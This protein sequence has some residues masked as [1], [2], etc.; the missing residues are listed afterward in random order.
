MSP[1]CQQVCLDLSCLPS[2]SPITSAGNVVL[3]L[4]RLSSSVSRRVDTLSKVSCSFSNSVGPCFCVTT[5][6]SFLDSG[7]YSVLN[8]K[9]S[10]YSISLASSIACLSVV[11]FPCKSS[12]R[13]MDGSSPI[14]NCCS[15][16]PDVEASVG[17]TG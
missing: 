3:L 9:V 17:Y 4:L 1:Q 15:K 8:S 7:S 10:A 11:S 5:Y 6:I 14:R 12:C 16:M 13:P 2:G